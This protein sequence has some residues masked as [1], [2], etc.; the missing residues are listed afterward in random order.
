M[1]LTSGI[2]GG[3][4]KGIIDLPNWQINTTGHLKLSENVVMLLLSKKKGPPTLPFQISGLLNQPNV[5]LDTRKF[6][7]SGISVPGDIGK[8]IDKILKK[9][10][11][12]S[13]LEKILPL[14]PSASPSRNPS[15]NAPPKLEPPQKQ[16]VPSKPRPEDLIK[17]LLR[18]VLR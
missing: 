11:I 9:K 5:R 15:P 17:N 1:T 13:I 3:I 12:G 14:G 16:S 6:S 4:A 18:D 8:R 2:G 7:S 10:G